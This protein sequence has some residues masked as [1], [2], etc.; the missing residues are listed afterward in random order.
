MEAF[1]RSKSS[2]VGSILFAIVL[3]VLLEQEIDL[4]VDLH[5]QANDAIDGLT[6]QRRRFGFTAPPPHTE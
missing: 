2:G 5:Q 6:I 1:A 4:R 3:V